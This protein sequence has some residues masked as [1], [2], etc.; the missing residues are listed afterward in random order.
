MQIHVRRAT[1][2]DAAIVTDFNQRLAEETEGHRLDPT[3]VAKGVRAALGDQSRALYYV[4]EADGRVV[5][6]T[7]ITFEWS[8]WR[9]GFLWWFGSVYV[10]P[11]FRGRGVFRALHDRIERDA[12]AANAA[13]LRLYVWN[14]NARAQATYAKLGWTD[15]NYRVMERSLSGSEGRPR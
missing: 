8:D 3:T 11:D 4:A 6:Q 14:E 9:N 5:G 13:S 12:R 10:E 1:L 15:A 7:L 2:A